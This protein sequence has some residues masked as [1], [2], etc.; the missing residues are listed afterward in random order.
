MK[1]SGTNWVARLIC[2]HPQAVLCGELHLELLH[3]AAR[4][5]CEPAWVSMASDDIEAAWPAMARAALDAHLVSKL[6]GGDQRGGPWTLV[7]HT[8]GWLAL[9][10]GDAGR[11]VHVVRDVRDVIVSDAFHSMNHGEHP[12]DVAA[13]QAAHVAAWREDASY[14]LRHPAALLHHAEVHR[15]A[16]T[17]VD[18]VTKAQAAAAEH[19]DLVELVRYEDLHADLRGQ[20]TR[21]LELAGLDPAQADA[22]LDPDL[23]PAFGGRAEDPYAFNRKGVVGDHVAYWSA[24]VDATVR[25][26]AGDLMARL[27][28]T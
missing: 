15:L 8:P 12:P 23:L 10:V 7:D 16:L 22:D 11:Y 18:I 21:L 9:H 24:D 3:D 5:Y 25:S 19:P 2:S 26:L 27:G 1:K 20:R 4:A 17:W 14:F 13:D 6:A 28:Y